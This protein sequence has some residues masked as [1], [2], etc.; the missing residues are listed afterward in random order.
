MVRVYSLRFA[1]CKAAQV[2]V[3]QLI[4]A[5]AG[6]ARAPA[7][8]ADERTNAVI[9]AG[10][11][12][13]HERVAKLLQ[14]MDVPQEPLRKADQELRLYELQ[15]AKAESAA[16]AIAP[17]LGPNDSIS[18]DAERNL[19]VVRAAAASHKQVASLLEELDVVTPA[20]AMTPRR[21]RIVW[22][23]SGLPR[24]PNSPRGLPADLKEIAAEL[25]KVGVE[26]LQV[27]AQ[28]MARCVGTEQFR[29]GG[30]AQVGGKPCEVQ[31]SGAFAQR[32]P[33]AATLKLT[34][35][36]RQLRPP[37][38]G[39]PPSA[40]QYVDISALETTITAPSGHPVVLGLTPMGKLNSV[41]VITIDEGK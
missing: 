15:H 2:A 32:S 22:L 8:V 10:T 20:E 38:G 18:A 27:A 4:T 39:K 16:R 26:D 17:L 40:A 35:T 34:V 11:P 25:A 1:E 3:Q 37:E 33:A 21:L 41:F 13:Q 9:V 19:L 7:L 28:F 5:G 14:A 12:Q 29:A 30:E 6:E 31:V 23:V 36:V 24:D